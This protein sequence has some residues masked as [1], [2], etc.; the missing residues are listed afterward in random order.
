M[1]RVLSGLNFGDEREVDHEDGDG[2]NN[3]RRNLRIASHAQNQANKGARC[4][5][6]SGLKGVYFCSDRNKYRAQIRVNGRLVSL[7]QYSTAEMASSAYIAAA[8]IH[9]GEF[10]HV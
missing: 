3:T 4:D 9:F 1:H 6:A 5:N 2:L 7:G 10:A 8:K